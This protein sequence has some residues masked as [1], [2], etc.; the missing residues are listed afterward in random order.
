MATKR[1]VT[2]Q[3]DRAFWRDVYSQ[4]VAGILLRHDGHRVNIDTLADNA[5]AHADA[6]LAQLHRRRVQWGRGAP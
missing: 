4:V 3:A 5:A 1:T 6:A 2:S